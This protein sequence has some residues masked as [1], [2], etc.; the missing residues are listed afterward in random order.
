MWHVMIRLAGWLVLIITQTAAEQPPSVTAVIDQGWALQS[1]AAITA[2]HSGSDI[3]APDYDTSA[4]CVQYPLN[5][6]GLPAKS[7]SL[8]CRTWRM[9]AP[10]C[11]VDS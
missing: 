1:R 2:G 10:E 3:S 11:R 7:Q 8:P 5:P 9:H 6:R 4:W